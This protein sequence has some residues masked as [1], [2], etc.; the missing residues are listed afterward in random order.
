MLKGFEEQTHAL[1]E[2]ETNTLL[3]LMVEGFKNKVGKE[4]AVTNKHICTSLKQMGYKVDAPRVR[5]IVSYIRINHLVPLLIATSKGYWISNDKQEIQDWIETMNGRIQS[6]V[7]SRDAV[8]HEYKVMNLRDAI[9]PQGIQI[10]IPN[11]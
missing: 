2:Y 1:N 8:I 11:N 6:L 3:P 10:M 7:A 4:N 9:Q 5:K